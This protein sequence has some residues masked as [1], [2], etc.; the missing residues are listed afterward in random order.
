[1]RPRAFTI[2]ASAGGTTYTPAFVID[3]F[4]NPTCMGIGLAVTGS[5][6]CDLQETFSSPRAIN[7]NA[8][9]VSNTAATGI[10][11]TNATMNGATTNSDTNY[12]FPSRAIRGAIRA[13]ASATATF[14]FIQVGPE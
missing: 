2:T 4:N 10:W 13:A 14:T 11:I 3:G 12:A 9:P 8:D 1:M 7:L 5:A 6:V